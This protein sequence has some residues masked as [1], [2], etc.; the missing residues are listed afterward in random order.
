MFSL[1]AQRATKRVLDLVVAVLMLVA[2]APVLGVAALLVRI[3]LGSPV[4]FVQERTG[5]SLRRFRIYK[6]RTMTAERDRHG[7]LLSD[8][9]R[10]GGLGRV[11]RRF[12]IDELPQLVNIIRGDLSLVGPRPLLPRYDPWYTDR[13]LRRFSVRP[14]ITGL[15]Q[16]SGRNGVAWDER[17]ELDVRYV[18]DWTL[19]LDLWILLRTTGKVLGGSGVATDPSARMLDLDKERELSCLPS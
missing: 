19:R 10:C 12:S 7:R 2:T 18:T 1:P 14:G 6:L 13:E 5:R 15:A 8:G 11:L 3:R 9:E 16:V 4:F 17:L